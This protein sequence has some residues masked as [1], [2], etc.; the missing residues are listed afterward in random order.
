LAKSPNTLTDRLDPNTMLADVM[1]KQKE[2]EQKA[3]SLMTAKTETISSTTPVATSS[4]NEKALE[5]NTQLMEMLSGKLD[6]MISVLESGNDVSSK[7][8]K[9]SRV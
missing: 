5:M 9:S 6:T 4:P 2:A 1:Q 3:M 8:L 7:I